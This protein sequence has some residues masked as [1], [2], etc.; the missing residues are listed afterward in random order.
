VSDYTFQY[1]IKGHTVLIK[2][3]SSNS[4]TQIQSVITELNV[5]IK[6][7]NHS[8]MLITEYNKNYLE[9]VINNALS[10]LVDV[11]KELNK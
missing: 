8:K 4:I 10:Q 9:N 3:L 1:A 5:I 6:L 7:S 2:L 11:K